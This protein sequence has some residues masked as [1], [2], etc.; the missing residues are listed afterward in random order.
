MPLGE[1]QL[2][3]TLENNGNQQKE[4]QANAN[5]KENAPRQ[6]KVCEEFFKHAL[7]QLKDTGRMVP[8]NAP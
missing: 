5:D 4:E 3:S 2:G 1:E 7:S 6:T 8:Q